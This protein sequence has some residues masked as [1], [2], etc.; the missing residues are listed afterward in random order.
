MSPKAVKHLTV[1]RTTVPQPPQQTLLWPQTTTPRLRHLSRYWVSPPN[2]SRSLGPSASM[3]S[4]ALRGEL[5]NFDTEIYGKK[6][7]TLHTK[8]PLRSVVEAAAHFA[9]EEN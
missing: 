7:F 4:S 2:L 8:C 5:E 9:D 3:S 6:G 1:Q